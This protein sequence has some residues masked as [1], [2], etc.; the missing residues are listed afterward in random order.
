MTDVLLGPDDEVFTDAAEAERIIFPFD[1]P[2]IRAAFVRIMADP[3]AASFIRELME[4]AEENASPVNPLVEG[5]DL[6]RLFDRILSQRGL[7]RAGDTARGA[8]VQPGFANFALGSV[9]TNNAGIQIGRKFPPVPI[10][11]GE[12][13][14]SY[15]KTDTRTALHETLHLAGE[16]F[17]DDR[18][19]ALVVSAMTNTPPPPAG[20][21]AANSRYWDAELRRRCRLT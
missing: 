9:V 1:V 13:K 3:D 4:R 19:Y 16:S 6:L 2:G 5:T 8:I 21:R 14:Q 18:A 7:I 12:L 20:D 17:Y 10:T 15:L 11:L